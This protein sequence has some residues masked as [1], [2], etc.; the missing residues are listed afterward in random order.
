[1]RRRHPSSSALFPCQSKLRL[2]RRV[3][4]AA[5]RPRTPAYVGYESGTWA[6]SSTHMLPA[7]ATAASRVISTAR[8]PTTWQPR[9]F[10]ADQLR[11]AENLLL[12]HPCEGVHVHHDGVAPSAQH[13]TVRS[14]RFIARVDQKLVHICETRL[15]CHPRVRGAHTEWLD[16]SVLCSG[17]QCDAAG[18]G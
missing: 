14:L 6:R 9:I 10:R 2:S 12:A 13:L 5:T 4:T 8:S 1:M 18:G 16:A 17:R 15:W 11:A 3:A 7:M